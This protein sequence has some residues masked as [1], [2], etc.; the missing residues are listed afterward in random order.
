MRSGRKPSVKAFNASGY[1]ILDQDLLTRG[2]V[3]IC[4][5]NP[6]PPSIG[7]LYTVQSGGALHEVE[8]DKVTTSK[9]G[10]AAHCK[11]FGLAA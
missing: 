2:E 4:S 8:V 10:W 9:R 5:I 1:E 3:V 7:D 6:G 11:L